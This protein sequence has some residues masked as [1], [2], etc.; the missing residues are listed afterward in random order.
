MGSFSWLKADPL[1][2]VANIVYKQPFKMLIPV[3]FGGGYI[4]DNYRD[5]GKI[6]IP[7]NDNYH[8]GKEYDMYELLAFWNWGMPYKTGIV[9][10]YLRGNLAETLR[11]IYYRENEIVGIIPLQPINPYTNENRD[12][13]IDIGCD[14]HDIDALQY[15]LKLVSCT[16]NYTYEQTLGRSYSDPNQGWGKLTREELQQRHESTRGSSWSSNV[17]HGN[18]YYYGECPPTAE[19][20]KI[21][22]LSKEENKYIKVYDYNNYNIT[23]NKGESTMSVKNNENDT[24][25]INSAATKDAC[26]YKITIVIEAVQHGETDSESV[27]CSNTA[28][29]ATCKHEI[30]Y[31]RRNCT[32]NEAM[33]HA[34]NTVVELL[35]NLDDLNFCMVDCKTTIL[36]ISE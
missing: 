29:I 36:P 18:N 21:K 24:T 35:N 3:E 25:S 4:Q 33:V 26:N 5:Y 11:E 9:L 10:D 8:D 28:D 27:Y 31:I 13:G 32:Y 15:P 34:S 12:I 17:Y 1:T 30:N 20:G 23:T 22:K 2:K 6:G 19:L 14:K 7:A 16:W